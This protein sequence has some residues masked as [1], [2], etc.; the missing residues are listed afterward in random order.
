MEKDLEN[1]L[2][3]I[4]TWEIFE[5]RARHCKRRCG[6]NGKKYQTIAGVRMEIRGAK[7]NVGVL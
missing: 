2:A 1:G 6:L 5:K 4:K 3:D 7:E